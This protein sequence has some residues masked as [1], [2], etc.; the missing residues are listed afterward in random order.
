[1]SV[2]EQEDAQ[3]RLDQ[4]GLLM[5]VSN[6]M[7]RLYKTQFGRGP[8]KVRTNWAGP[9]TIITT[10]ENSLTPAE[11][12]MVT[13]GELQRLRDTRMFFQYAIEGQFREV[14][15]RLTGREVWAFVSG[16]DAAQDVSCEIFYLKPRA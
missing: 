11:R 15:E 8:T 1:M 7:V 3:A 6:E 16:I 5:Q 13:M 9:D 14:V 4:K 10:L 12:N 2:D